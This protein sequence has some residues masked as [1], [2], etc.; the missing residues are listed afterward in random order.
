MYIL[1]CND[2]D[3]DNNNNAKANLQPPSQIYR[4]CIIYRNLTSVHLSYHAGFR[5][6]LIVLVYIYIF[7]TEALER[8]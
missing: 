7:H 4:S 2:V 5:L 1:F 6:E 8:K 3:D